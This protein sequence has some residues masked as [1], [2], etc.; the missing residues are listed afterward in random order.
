MD[1]S[2]SSSSLDSS[3]SSSLDSEPEP[4]SL[5]E[6]IQQCKVMKLVIIQKIRTV[7]PY[8]FSSSHA[9]VAVS[10]E[11]WNIEICLIAEKPVFESAP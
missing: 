9:T 3:S 5:D 1:E 4:E 7:Y 10:K 2:S 6:S 8:L 11:G